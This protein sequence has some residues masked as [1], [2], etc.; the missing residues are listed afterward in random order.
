MLTGPLRYGVMICVL[1]FGGFGAWRGAVYFLDKTVPEV[2]LSGIE[3]NAY[4][5]GDVQCVITMADVAGVRDLS[6]YLDGKPLVNQ[7]RINKR[8]AEHTFTVPT[9]AMPYGK[10]ELRVVV[11]DRS[12][13]HNATT[14]SVNFMVDNISLQAAFTRPEHDLK[15]FQGRT[16]HVM[17]QVSKPVKRA[18]ARVLGR[19][20]IC[21]P[22]DTDSVIYECFIPVACEDRPSEYPLV[23]EI[24][25]Y[26][27]NVVLLETKLQVVAFP[28]LQQRLT[29][30][31][32]DIDRERAA[33]ADE[34][35]L[36][37]L[38]QA[39]LPRSP[40]RKLWRGSFYAPIDVKRTS[41]AFG[42]VRTTQH[43]GKYVH[44][45]VDLVGE[46][47]R[48]VWAPQDGIIIVRDRFEHS[49]NTIVIDHGCGIFTLY[50]HLDS[51][52]VYE[53]GDTVHQGNPIG[54]IGKTGFANGYHL[55]WGLE[56]NGIAVDPMQ[57]IQ[58]DF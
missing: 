48:V 28:F 3:M 19:E 34:R 23:I 2:T 27:G 38:L 7:Y 45:A 4:Y 30:K 56:V 52:G 16:V 53:V 29:L 37:E 25:D 31:P 13:N 6:I 44:A 35:K 58:D 15:V 5:A 1:V 12:F 51:Y 54:T 11:T 21:V 46:P 9:V 33:G 10:H 32:E 47:K 55:H 40:Q 18:V 8:Q 49:G 26:V 57:W 50:F 43:R 42:T 22:E 41:T 20:V 17:F 39:A 36:N 14:E 24:T